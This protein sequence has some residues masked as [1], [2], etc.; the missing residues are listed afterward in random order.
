MDELE[1]KKQLLKAI[2]NALASISLESDSFFDY[3]KM[4]DEEIEKIY[5]RLV[6]KYG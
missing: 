3:N 4:T 6:V 2:K 1:R 5:K